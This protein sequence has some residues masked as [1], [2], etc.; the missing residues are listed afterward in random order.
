[1]LFVLPYNKWIIKIFLKDSFDIKIFNTFFV[2]STKDIVLIYELASR[3]T[4]KEHF[5]DVPHGFQRNFAILYVM[6]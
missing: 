2:G 4:Y 5:G 1:M 3:C 6:L